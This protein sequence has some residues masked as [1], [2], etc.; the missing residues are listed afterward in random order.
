MEAGGPAPCRAALGQ[1]LH[2]E[3]FC[4][5]TEPPG[6]APEGLSEAR[7]APQDAACSRGGLGT[8]AA[9]NGFL[10]VRLSC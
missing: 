2:T 4:L 8:L 9:S 1:P 3:Q 5:Q 10:P 6:P 7:A